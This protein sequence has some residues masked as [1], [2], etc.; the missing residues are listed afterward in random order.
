MFMHNMIARGV[1]RCASGL[2][3]AAHGARGARARQGVQ[4]M[5]RAVARWKALNLCFMLVRA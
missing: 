3:C 4:A 1:H 2:C 5:L